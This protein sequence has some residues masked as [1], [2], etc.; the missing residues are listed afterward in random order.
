MLSNINL[1][2]SSG[3]RVCLVGRNGEGKSTLLKILAGNI[4]PDEGKV[5]KQ[6]GLKT[7]LLSQ[8]IDSIEGTVFDVVAGG[9]EDLSEL[10]TKYQSITT[11]LKFDKDHG[12]LSELEDVQHQLE[13]AGG[14]H[15]WQKVKS[16]LS[17][18]EL[19]A[20]IDFSSLSGGMKRKTLLGRALV[21]KPDLL[22]L[23]EPTNHLD[24]HSISWLED[25]L[26]TI[27]TTLVFVTHD[28]LLA[29]KIATRILDLD[30][31]RLTSWACGFS[32]YLARKDDQ[33]TVEK[34]V[35]EKF[36]KRLSQE[37]AWIRQGIKARRTRNEGR[38]RA[39]KSMREERRARRL[40][41]GKAN[42]VLQEASR[43]G[44]LVIRAENLSFCYAD[45]EIIRQF[46][47]TIIR[48]D[49]VGIIGPNGCGKTT[50]VGL[51]LG[52]LTSPSGNVRLGSNLQIIYF[53]QLRDRLDENSTVAEAIGEGKEIITINGRNKHV[54]GYLKDFLFTPDRARSP[55][56]ILSGGERNR[57]L[58]AQLFSRP[59]NVLVLDEPTNDLDVETLELLEELLLEFN[60]TVILVSHDRTFLNNVVTSTIVFE[61][62]GVISEY[63]GGYDDWLKQRNN[64][65]G[66]E[67]DK[68]LKQ[69]KKERTEKKR[70]RKLT[71]KE[72][73]ELDELPKM[74]EDMEKEQ[75]LLF[76]KLASPEFYQQEEGVEV[77]KAKQRLAEL[78][79]GLETAY[80]RWEELDSITD[81]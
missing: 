66:P 53:D 14:W 74:I 16:V 19:D 22:L 44:K 73:F 69:A 61:G 60:G 39:L 65:T 48:G 41:T 1:Q 7:A 81:H 31:G 5:L 72:R 63:I 68:A 20:E 29:D 10:L 55:V 40:E 28:R 80:N 13:S 33:L 18:L 47:T 57:L 25:F 26:L 78:E 75:Q 17:R 77:K 51:L 12:L 3:E 56:R 58:L 24:I 34:A 2:I 50:L 15:L 11:R 35:Q 79:K 42:I 67:I 36:D 59:A 64:W 8:E 9:L 23:D 52:K 49:K 38:V 70:S 54:I 62:N 6:S 4:V 21:T 71:F 43:S 37:E 45:K 76:E 32:K 27:D 46:S 30:R